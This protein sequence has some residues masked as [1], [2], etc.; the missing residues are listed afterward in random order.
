M[1]SPSPLIAVTATVRTDDGARRVRLN[2]AYPRAIERAGGIPVVV[3]PLLRLAELDRVLDAVDGLLLTGG[4]DIDPAHYKAP[5]HPATEDPN[6]ERDATELALVA[7]ARRRSLPTLAICRGIQLLDVALGGTLVQDIP[8]ERSDAL[9]HDPGGP[10][11]ARVHEVRIEPGSRLAA[12]LGATCLTVNSFHHQSVDRVADGLRA[13]AWSPD[14]I[15][16]GVEWA[17]DDWWSVA[18]QWHPEELVDGSEEWD[19]QLF[20]AFIDCASRGGLVDD[21]GRGAEKSPARGG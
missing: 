1:T 3:P 12:A 10:R 15:I 11:H 21:E 20:A 9:A 17:A 13:T 2:A 7:A 4:E 5:R 16:E 19:R 8:S 6:A 18:V 14:G